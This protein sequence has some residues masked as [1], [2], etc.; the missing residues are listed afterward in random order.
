MRI[1]LLLIILLVCGPTCAQSETEQIDVSNNADAQQLRKLW[2]A[3][4][5]PVFRCVG[6]NIQA[7]KTKD[8]AEPGCFCEHQEQLAADL[9]KVN[10]IRDR[11][12]EWT[13]K[14][15]LFIEVDGPD[16]TE[17][18]IPPQNFDKIQQGADLPCQ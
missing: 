18:S 3:A 1:G 13:G 11:H 6:L 15:L 14:R 4:V 10:E 5:G 2:F 16:K 12:P 17:F 8:E 7:G 9:A